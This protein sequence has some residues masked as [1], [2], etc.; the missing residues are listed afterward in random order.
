MAE[1]NFSPN[2]KHA[3]IVFVTINENAN[4]YQ[5]PRIIHQVQWKII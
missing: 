1:D 5:Q 4:F 2:Y 3:A